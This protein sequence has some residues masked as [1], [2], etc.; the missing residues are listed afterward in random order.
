MKDEKIK[1]INI[2][3]IKDHCD[4]VVLYRLPFQKES[5]ILL[6]KSRVLVNGICDSDLNQKGFVFNPFAKSKGKCFFID[7]VFEEVYSSVLL[8]RFDSEIKRLLTIQESGGKL[9]EQ[10]FDSYSDQFK[11]MYEA[12]SEGTLDKVILS[13]LKKEDGLSSSSIIPLF[14][15]LCEMYPHAFVY[16]INSPISGLWIGAGPELLL[17]QEGGQLQT[18][19]LA[20]TLPNSDELEWGEKELKEQAL[21]TDYMKDKLKNIGIESYREEGPYSMKAGQVQ[22]LRTDFSFAKEQLKTNTS[23][24]LYQLHPTPAVCGMPKEKAK[25]LIS[26]CENYDREYYSGFLGPINY[27]EFAFF[28]NIR[29]LKL[30]KES[31]VLYVGGGLTKGSELQKEWDETELKAQTL[32]SVMKNMRNLQTYE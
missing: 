7:S 12:L 23:D 19:S 21:V 8:K 4:S 29:C 5:K 13:R 31:A 24:L 16:V 11:K 25:L 6:G 10:D 3:K 1:T 18:V 32:L 28:V 30:F 17:K 15:S 22:H 2:Q 14:E 20:G 26:E 9:S 27:D